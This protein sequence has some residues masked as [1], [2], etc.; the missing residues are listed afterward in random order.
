MGWV[1][2]I[3]TNAGNSSAYEFFSD[4]IR[5]HYDVTLEQCAGICETLRAYYKIENWY[6][7]D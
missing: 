2:E 3:T 6:Y 4:Y 1:K 5:D 7:N